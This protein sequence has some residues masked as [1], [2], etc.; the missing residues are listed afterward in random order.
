MYQK[1]DYLKIVDSLKDKTLLL[2]SQNYAAFV[3]D[4]V[5]CLA[6]CYRHIHVLAVTRPIAEVSNFLPLHSLKPFRKKIKINL[7]D[8][9][10]NVSVFTTPLNYFP[11]NSC[12]KKVGDLHLKAVRKV[13]AKNDIS[14]DIIHCHFTYSS[15]YVGACLKNEY[16]VPLLITGHGFD[17][18]DLPFRDTFWQT[19]VANTLKAADRIITV[20]R[21][22]VSCIRK[23][24]VKTPVDLLPNG[25]QKNIFFPLEKAFCRKKLNLPKTDQT[26]VSVGNLIAVKGHTYLIAAM[27]ELVKQNKSLRCYIIGSGGLKKKL[28]RQI[29]ECDL[30]QN[31]FLVGTLPHSE[32]VCW[33]NAADVF[34]LPSLKEGNPTV[35]FESLACGCPFVGADVGGVA[36]IVNDE[37]LGYLFQPGNVMDMANSMRI[38]LSKEWDKSCIIDYAQT[39]SWDCITAEIVKSHGKAFRSCFLYEGE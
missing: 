8:L 10:E 6:S 36:E 25:Y 38:A 2:I 12:Y 9:P 4:Q 3:K 30:S 28:E 18:Y 33:L 24:G 21:K 13:L 32:L 26:V 35:L 27:A 37:K 39:Y 1:A 34:V 23:I 22:N 29:A 14:F 7:S 20:S 11:I 17:V 19:L 15:G 31:V 16:R 5:E